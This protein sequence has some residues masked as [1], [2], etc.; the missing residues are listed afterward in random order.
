MWIHVDY[1]GAPHGGAPL[2]EVGEG[3]GWSQNLRNPKDTI[4]L[5]GQSHNLKPRRIIPKILLRDDRSFFNS[6]D[7]S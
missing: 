1:I 3:R 4:V 5:E 6:D 2:P 7:R